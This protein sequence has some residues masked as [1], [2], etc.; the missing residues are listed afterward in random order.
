MTK[1]R[2]LGHLQFPVTL[3]EVISGPA[4]QSVF[5]QRETEDFI[6]GWDPKGLA[7][8]LRRP[9]GCG[10]TEIRQGGKRTVLPS[11]VKLLLRTSEEMRPGLLGPALTW[12]HRNEHQGVCGGAC[13][14]DCFSQN[15]TRS[16]SRVEISIA[17][18][19][20]SVRGIWPCEE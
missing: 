17:S 11:L 2:A 7:S 16:S 18:A 20:P 10:Q 19:Q 4:F 13:G 9:H 3:P 1:D 14:L 8:L 15:L 5:F 12:G 6:R